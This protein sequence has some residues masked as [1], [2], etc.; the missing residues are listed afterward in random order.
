MIFQKLVR[1]V[2]VFSVV[3]IM[4]IFAISFL[5]KSTEPVKEIVGSPVKEIY[6]NI[7]CLI[8]CLTTL[9]DDELAYISSFS[10]NT[11]DN[12]PILLEWF[13]C[14]QRIMTISYLVNEMVKWDNVDNALVRSDANRFEKAKEILFN[15]IK[16]P[17]F[18]K[19]IDPMM[20]FY[21][22][23]QKDDYLFDLNFIPCYSKNTF[24]D[25]L[26][27]DY[28]IFEN[29]NGTDIDNFFTC[30]NSST[31]YSLCL[32]KSYEGCHAVWDTL[33]PQV[34]LGKTRN[35]TKGRCEDFALLYYSLFR[36]I[37]VS[38]KN[39][40]LTIGK[41]AL[42]C[43][44]RD[45]VDKYYTTECVVPANLTVKGLGTIEGCKGVKYLPEE[46]YGLFEVYKETEKYTFIAFVKQDFSQYPLFRNITFDGNY[47]NDVFFGEKTIESP[48]KQESFSETVPKTEIYKPYKKIF[49][50]NGKA[51]FGF[52]INVD[53]DG[54]NSIIVKVGIGDSSN[55]YTLQSG[56]KRSVYAY[57][58]GVP[59]FE[60]IKNP[61][62]VVSYTVSGLGAVPENS[63]CSGGT[64][65]DTFVSGICYPNDNPEDIHH[66]SLDDFVNGVCK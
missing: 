39:L 14:N 65:K 51:R 18:S 47:S 3:I 55:L 54:C 10:F 15:C 52:T 33:W 50:F 42:P 64:L 2:I 20:S 13:P 31:R 24:S 36:S 11:V 37:D 46:Y 45:K 17:Y 59:Y 66:I 30:K 25:F 29:R 8:N 38:P 19:C 60:I 34:K 44:W 6:E 23:C 27:R 43:V 12:S 22:F 7:P 5:P 53:L 4:S 56:E 1:I 40:T 26:S 48:I 58:E 28:F 49:N 16:Y 32:P 62:C 21:Y 61:N 35:Y 9:K 63:L 41:C 57:G